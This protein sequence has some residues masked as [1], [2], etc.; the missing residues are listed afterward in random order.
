VD[1]VGT[2]LRDAL[3]RLDAAEGAA[4]LT[5]PGEPQAAV[6]DH[7]RAGAALLREALAAIEQGTARAA[8]RTR[9]RDRFDALLDG[10]RLVPRDALDQVQHALRR[11]GPLGDATLDAV[12]QITAACAR[13]FYTVPP[14][15]LSVP[16]RAHVDRIAALSGLSAAPATR[17]RLHRLL[18]DAAAFAGWLGYDLGQ[19]GGARAW[20]G[21]AGS[22]A[23]EAGDA[24]LHAL[25]VGSTGQSHSVF[26]NGIA[27][28]DPRR[29]LWFLVQAERNL[30]ADAPARARAWLW[31]L[32][33]RESAVNGD[34]GNA[35]RYLDLAAQ[36]HAGRPPADAAGGFLA[37][38]GWFR[39]LEDPWWLDYTRGRTLGR[40]GDDRAEA[41]LTGV[42]GG[43][44]DLR[45]RCNAR[46]DLTE[47][48]LAGD[49]VDEAARLAC[50][51]LPLAHD[52]G[53]VAHVARIRGIRDLAP[54]R[55]DA[56]FALFDN[57]VAQL[58]RG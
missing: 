34:V 6:R 45:Q 26:L 55:T 47:L 42:A 30:P 4:R 12:E 29:A 57:L 36:A 22:A 44:P 24:A 21:L 2:R 37:D 54:A 15:T 31:A 49:D 19:P 27:E 51:V 33:A 38:L 58:S 39:D 52:A 17:T 1:D 14:E 23:R 7:V 43:S 3:A 32:N 18:A 48:R 50:E 53:L 28:G 11:R 20:F 10:A 46:L 5:R 13:A 9:V 25:A 16:V 8:A 56:A 40:L 35:H 41:L